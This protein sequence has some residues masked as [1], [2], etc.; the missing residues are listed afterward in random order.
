MRLVKVHLQKE[1][2]DYVGVTHS[3][4]YIHLLS[5]QVTSAYQHKGWGYTQNTTKCRD[6]EPTGLYSGN[7]LLWFDPKE[8]SSFF[9]ARWLTLIPTQTLPFALCCSEGPNPGVHVLDRITL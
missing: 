2:H 9:N 5:M 4:W 6:T 3:R 7:A 8:T 1:K